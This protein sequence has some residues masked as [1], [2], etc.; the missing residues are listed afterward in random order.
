MFDQTFLGKAPETFEPVDI[1]LAAGIDLVAV[2]DFEVALAAEYQGIVDMELVRVDDASPANL[3]HRH[4]YER[5]GFD[6]GD[7]LYVD[8]SVPFQDA[9]HGNLSCSSAATFPF[10]PAAEVG[11]V[12]L[13]L[14]AQE[15]FCI[16]CVSEYGSTNNHDN[17]VSD[18]VGNCHLLGDLPGGKLQ[19]EELDDPEPLVAGKVDEIEPPSREVVERVP[20][21]GAATTTVSQLVKFPL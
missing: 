11:F 21:T 14:T 9:K 4:A 7:D 5:L 2:V 12:E 6:V 20:A 10:A 3:L 8:E 15:R 18:L 19:L 17:S 13:D 1:D 16:G